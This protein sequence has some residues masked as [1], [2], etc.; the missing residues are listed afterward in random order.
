MYKKT[1]LCCWF[2]VVVGV[3]VPSSDQNKNVVPP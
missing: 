1:S 2:V 3:V